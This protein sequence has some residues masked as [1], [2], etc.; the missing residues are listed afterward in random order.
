MGASEKGRTCV[1]KNPWPGKTVQLISNG[2][3]AVLLTGNRITF[4][5]KE[6]EL[7]MWKEM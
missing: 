2:K 4:P 7:I 3:K 5:T 1:I 6:N